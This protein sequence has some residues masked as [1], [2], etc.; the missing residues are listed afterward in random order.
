MTVVETLTTEAPVVIAIDDLQ[1]LDP[2]S[3]GV[4]SFVARRLRGRV[5]LLGTARSER[6]RE[7]VLSWLQLGTPDEI[8]RVMV[9]PLSLGG[10][11]QLLSLRLGR[12]L[13]RPTMVHFA[14]LSGGNPFYALEIARAIDGKRT[15]ADACLPHTLADLVRIRTGHLAGDAADV[16]LAAACAANPT[17][18]MLARATSI[19]VE[20]TTEL[21]DEADRNGAVVMDGNRVRYS[22]PLLAHGIYTGAAPARRRQMHRALAEVVSQ[23]E[24]KARHLA[25]AASSTNPECWRRSTMP[26]RSPAQGE[27]RLPRQNCS[28]WQ[29]NSVVIRQAVGSGPP[30]T[31]SGAVTWIGRVLS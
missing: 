10:L 3:R 25:L 26:R 17:V 19:S 27:R 28:I 22:H 18:E 14:D 11:H 6:D 24:L 29:S 7:S 4:V 8:R 2:T 12:A 9:G 31:I 20:R 5:F 23:P 15:T 1:W 13:P 30:D 16:L 21:L